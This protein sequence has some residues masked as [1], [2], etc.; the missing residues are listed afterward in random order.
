MH[1]EDCFKGLGGSMNVDSGHCSDDRSWFAVWTRSRQEKVAASMLEVLGVSHFLPLKS[2]LRQWSDRK[3]TVYVPLF[4]GYLFVQMNLSKDSRLQ[5]LKAVPGIVGFV[6][7][8]AGPSPIPNQQIEDIRTVLTR[9]IECSVLP[10]LNEGEPV[11][12]VRG[13]LSGVE[14]SIIRSNSTSRMLISIAMIHKTIAVSVSRDDV[15]P[16]VPTRSLRKGTES[17]G[18]RVESDLT[19]LIHAPSW[20]HKVEVLC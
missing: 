5:V 14:G 12:V 20:L 16:I 7:N 17:S 6:G 2:E 4:S 19:H 15:V 18:H 1:R 8:S 3:Q 13:P 11:R 10:L 9:G